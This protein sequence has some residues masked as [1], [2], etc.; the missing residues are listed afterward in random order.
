MGG[1]IVETYLHRATET[2]AV[3]SVILDSP[4]LDYRAAIDTIAS[5]L[6]RVSASSGA[7]TRNRAPS[8]SL[9]GRPAHG[10]RHSQ[11]RHASRAACAAGSVG[12]GGGS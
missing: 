10:V 8:R 6:G 11:L 12:P 9:R 4:A 3:R 5:G 7:R 1:G 2:S